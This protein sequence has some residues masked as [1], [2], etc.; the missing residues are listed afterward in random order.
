MSHRS[1]RLPTAD[2]GQRI[3]AGNFHPAELTA[4][5]FRVLYNPR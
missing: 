1:S 4:L 5:V 3:K 2:H